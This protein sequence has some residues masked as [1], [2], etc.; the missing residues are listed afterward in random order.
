MACGLNWQL[1]EKSQP[2][3]QLHPLQ[4]TFW[5]RP[6]CNWH[7]YCG[8]FS[9]GTYRAN[10]RREGSP[11]RWEER[12]GPVMVDP[13]GLNHICNSHRGKGVIRESST[14]HANNNDAELSWLVSKV[15]CSQLKYVLSLWI[16]VVNPLIQLLICHIWLQS[17]RIQRY[18]QQYWRY[19]LPQKIM[20]ISHIRPQILNPH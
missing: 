12:S 10:K 6:S 18:F 16:F 14:K 9:G 4:R 8:L 15:N 20:Q 19:S 2:M 17:F 5:A 11:S 13:K 3:K 7:T 1:L